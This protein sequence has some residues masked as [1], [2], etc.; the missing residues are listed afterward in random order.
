MLLSAADR[1]VSLQSYRK[2]LK[3]VPSHGS[4]GWILTEQ[5]IQKSII[6][7]DSSRGS[8]RTLCLKFPS[9]R[10]TKT[11]QCPQTEQKRNVQDTFKENCKTLLKVVKCCKDDDVEDVTS[12]PLCPRLFINLMKF[13][14]P[15]VF[16]FF[17]FF[18]GCLECSI[19]GVSLFFLVTV[20]GFLFI[21]IKWL[22]QPG[23]P[24]YLSW[25]CV[26]WVLTL[27]ATEPPSKG[28]FTDSCK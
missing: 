4:L 2:L 28:P 23:L 9:R 18:L 21:A 26:S 15:V 16:F 22:T 1:T 27:Y 11:G 8:C 13:C 20:S 14:L 12:F 7:L 19:F 24:L 17:F 5:T 25:A 3:I 10:T 6:L